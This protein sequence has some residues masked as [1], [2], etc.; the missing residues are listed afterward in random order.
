ME[1]SLDVFV[2]YAYYGHKREHS[3]QIV[4]FRDQ[5]RRL[6]SGFGGD[7]GH[8]IVN[9]TIALHP[10]CDCAGAHLADTGGSAVDNRVSGSGATARCDVHGDE[11]KR[12][13]RGAVAAG[14]PVRE[15]N[16]RCGCDQHHGD[17]K[18]ENMIGNATHR[19][20][21]VVLG[22]SGLSGMAGIADCAKQ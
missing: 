11:H 6:S 20:A 12:Q 8:S 15:C 10:R 22:D 9:S 4:M 7:N 5:I 16:G 13:R 19:Y 21:F 14:D 17:G 2:A 18:I 1:Y 3:A